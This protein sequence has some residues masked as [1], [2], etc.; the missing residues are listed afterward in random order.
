MA[1][2]VL[3]LSC[4]YNSKPLLFALKTNGS[5]PVLLSITWAVFPPGLCRWPFLPRG[6]RTDGAVPPSLLLWD[7]RAHLSLRGAC[8]R[9]GALLEPSLC[10][11]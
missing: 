1:T 10:G 4:P 5:P 7:S 8:I 11:L 9:L 6:K 3:Q 2:R